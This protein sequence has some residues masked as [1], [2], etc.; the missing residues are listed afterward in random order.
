MPYLRGLTPAEQEAFL[1]KVR[2]SNRTLGDAISGDIFDEM[3]FQAI[4]TKLAKL[5]EEENFN[6][7]NRYRLQRTKLDYAD[8][9]RMPIDET[10]LK[11][12]LRN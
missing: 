7:K 2:N 11:D 6:S 4:E 3:T 9:K 1:H 12:V 10:K 8:K 5:S